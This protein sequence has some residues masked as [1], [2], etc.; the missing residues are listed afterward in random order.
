[1]LLSLFIVLAF[2]PLSH[3][4]YTYTLCTVSIYV[5]LDQRYGE[6]YLKEILSP[7]HE[8]VN[9]VSNQM[10]SRDRPFEKRLGEIKPIILEEGSEVTFR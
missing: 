8:F 9:G 3:Y 7:V 4:F 1:M 2:Y 6:R 10:T 5:Q